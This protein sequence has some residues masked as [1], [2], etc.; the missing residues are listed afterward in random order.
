MLPDI[1]KD[2]ISGVRPVT[3]LRDAGPLLVWQDQEDRIHTFGLPAQKVAESTS[4][5]LPL[6]ALEMLKVISM[7][8]DRPATLEQVILAWN[9]FVEELNASLIEKMRRVDLET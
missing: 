1:K 8:G 9:E 5:D 4:E 2:P 7:G 6:P 3:D